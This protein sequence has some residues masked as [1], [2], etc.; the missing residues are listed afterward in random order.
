MT[1]AVSA[2]LG[3]ALLAALLEPLLRLAM[4][5]P[6]S[7]MSAYYEAADR[8]NHG[9]PLYQV[10]MD[11]NNYAFYR[12]PPLLAIAFRPFALLPMPVISTT[13]AIA[14]TCLIL[15]TVRRLGIRPRTAAALAL[16]SFPIVW[17][18]ILGQ[19]QVLVTWLLAVGSPWSVA[20]AGQLKLFPG[21]GAL[22]WIGRRD[23]KSL[24]SFLAWT[25]AFV[26]LQFVLEPNGSVAFLGTLN[27]RQVG[28]IDNLSPYGIS[29]I[30]WAGF[31]ILL[32]GLALRLAPTRLG[33]AA[34]MVAA[35]LSTPRLISYWLM[36][37]LAAFRQPESGP[38]PRAKKAG[39][40]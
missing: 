13:W 3:L 25:I 27:L 9:Q 8:L 34:A 33:W 11:V 4:E 7:D 16:L 20:L 17:S 18:L 24:R 38:R 26:L 40:S 1:G 12:Y 39:L 22:Y 36:S 37:L 29:P 14:N 15:L 5:H 2:G 31:V 10:T 32:T 23:W 28:T 21:L 19:A 6:Q 30:A 35:T